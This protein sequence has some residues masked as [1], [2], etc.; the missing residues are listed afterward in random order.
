MHSGH[1]PIFSLI[2]LAIKSY[3]RMTFDIFTK[4]IHNTVYKK[5]N[6]APKIQPSMIQTKIPVS[7]AVYT[8]ASNDILI[9]ST[10]NVFLLNRLSSLNRGRN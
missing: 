9:R 2:Y 10:G 5:K 7:Q 3:F 8:I 6:D 1:K 4:T